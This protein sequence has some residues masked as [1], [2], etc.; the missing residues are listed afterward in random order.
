[1]PQIQTQSVYDPLYLNRDKKII[2]ITGGRGSGKSFNVS[3]FVQRSSFKKGRLF[4][5]CRYTMVSAGISVIPEFLEKVEMDGHSRYFYNRL[6]DV[7]NLSSGSKVLFRGIK[8]SSGNQTAKLK[9][10]HGLTDFICDEAEEWQSERE[11]DVLKLSLRKKG[12]TNRVF[13]IMNP[14]DEHHFIYRK[15]IKETHKIEY[16]DGV[17]VQISTHP[18]VL[19]IHTTYLDNLNHLSPEF[20]SYV[21]SIKEENPEKYAHTIIG[22]WADMSEGAI[23][24][25]V[26]LVDE[27]PDFARRRAL[28]IDFGY[29]N[30]PTAI[31][32]CAIHDDTLYIDELCYDTGMLT[33]DIIH[34]LAVHKG[35]KII[36][37]SADPRLVQEIANEGYY[38]LPVEKGAGSILAGITK[39]KEF[40][41]CVTKRSLNAREEFRKYCWAQD[42][43]GKYINQ[44]ASGQADHI[45]DCVRYYA[46]GELLGKILKPKVVSGDELP[47]WLP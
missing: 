38:I 6:S 3:T 36:S 18:D 4:L 11:F 40:K 46:L 32:E 35:K 26:T 42:M 10:I 8:T 34:R 19:H 2:L 16:F 24:P 39:V 12:I 21:L 13:I 29:T 33:K 41:L 28:A 25:S 5:Y 30:D 44:P 7:E 31:V 15:Y 45:M 14:T 27:I 43:D 9:S 37:E 47:S 1:M 20:I 23:F 22:R 17:P